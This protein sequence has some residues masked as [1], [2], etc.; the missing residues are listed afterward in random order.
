MIFPFIV[1]F[2]F[3]CQKSKDESSQQKSKYLRW[4]GDSKF[5]PEVDDPDFKA[6]NGEKVAQYFNFSM[7]LQYEGEKRALEKVF[8]EKYN[9][10]SREGESGLIRI[11]FVVNCKGK[12]GRFRLLQMDNDF[13]EKSFN[14]LITDQLLQI[15]KGLTGWKR[16]PDTDNARDY[17][18]Y[19]IFK[20]EKGEIKE[21]LP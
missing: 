17:Y 14:P 19:L 8:R 20:M 10:L 5:D 7:G 16:L 6:C 12:T 2:L 21:I 13:Q 4:V 9:P 3:G 11:R 15:T 18:Q 1:I